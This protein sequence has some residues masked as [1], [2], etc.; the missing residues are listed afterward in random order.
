[1]QK[2]K[3]IV[4]NRRLWKQKKK[5]RGVGDVEVR[6]VEDVGA[7]KLSCSRGARTRRAGA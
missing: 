7:A 4:G 6:C 5:L 2:K 1:M 3:K